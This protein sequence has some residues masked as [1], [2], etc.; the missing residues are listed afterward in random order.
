MKKTVL[1][2][3]VCLL[4]LATKSLAQLTA[5]MVFPHPPTALSGCAWDTQDIPTFANAVDACFFLDPSGTPQMALS[6]NGG[7][8]AQATGNGGGSVSSV[9][10]RQGAVV[11]AIGDYTVQQVTGAAPLLSPNLSGTP[12]TPTPTPGSNMNQI[13]NMTAVQQ[14]IAGISG[15]LQVGTSITF[16]ENTV[17]PKGG[18]GNIVLGYSTKNCTVTATVTAITQP[19]KLEHVKAGSSKTSKK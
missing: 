7:I 9:F 16:N 6:K 14:A 4:F 19:N 17:C 2:C 8:F 1:L 5:G 18:T 15:G 13:A 10:N 12:T 11:A 3:F